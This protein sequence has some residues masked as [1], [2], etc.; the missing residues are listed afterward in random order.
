[1]CVPGHLSFAAPTCPG[2]S[3]WPRSSCRSGKAAVPLHCLSSLQ[4]CMGG[5]V[6][7]DPRG[8]GFLLSSVTWVPQLLQLHVWESGFQQTSTSIVTFTCF[9][10]S[11]MLEKRFA[12]RICVYAAG[13]QVNILTNSYLYVY[14]LLDL[15][16]KKNKTPSALTLIL[17]FQYV[18]SNCM[19]FTKKIKILLLRRA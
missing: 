12:W 5:K 7:S 6:N 9:V 18:L 4:R 8:R 2:C 13:N 14:S 16:K 17:Q 19:L 15:E 3:V 11:K 10:S 1:M